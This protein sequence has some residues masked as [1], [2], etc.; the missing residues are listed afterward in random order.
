MYSA[1]SHFQSGCPSSSAVAHRHRTGARVA[2]GTGSS[3]E[4]DVQEQV[5][6]VG[7]LLIDRIQIGDKE[8]Q[9]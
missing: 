3:A 7:A 2:K 4:I 1:V 6:A 5:V 8:K 9:R